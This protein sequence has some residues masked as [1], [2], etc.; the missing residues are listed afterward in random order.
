MVNEF[1][2]RCFIA[3]VLSL[4]SDFLIDSSLT[5]KSIVKILESERHDVIFVFCFVWFLVFVLQVTFL[6]S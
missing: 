2:A 1:T 6:F 5:W 4:A 3:T